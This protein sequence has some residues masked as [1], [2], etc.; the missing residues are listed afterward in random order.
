MITDIRNLYSSAWRD[1]SEEIGS[2]IENIHLD[3]RDATERQ[4]LKHADKN[5]KNKM[6]AAFVAAVVL[7]NK[8][9]VTAINNGLDDI[10]KINAEDVRSYVSKS[11]GMDIPMKSANIDSLL[12][13]YTKKAYSERMNR[14]HVDK[15]I[16]S[17]INKILKEGKGTKEIA[18]ALDK[19]FYG[20]RSSAFRTA[21]TETTRVQARGRID[22]M[23]EAEKHG[24]KF[25]KIWRHGAFVKRPR[26][27][28]IEMDGQERDLDEMFD[29]PLGPKLIAPGDP[30]APA[31]EVISCHCFLDERLIVE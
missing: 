18:R 16:T 24:L 2:Y 21:L 7:S 28:H 30:N 17:V 25:K 20:N 5:G 11:T 3:D 9:A 29:S 13:K 10:Y 23:A 4:R 1:L 27:H 8:H 12:S 22:A 15:R 6:I 26:E 19:Q 14:S 31:S